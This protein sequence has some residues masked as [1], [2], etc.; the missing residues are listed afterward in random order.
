[1]MNNKKELS[2]EDLHE[3]IDGNDISNFDPV[4]EA[5]KLYDVENAGFIPKG[6]LADIF[7]AYGFDEMSNE[8]INTLVKAADIDGDGKVTLKDFRH[9]MGSIEEVLSMHTVQK[10]G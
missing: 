7:Q 3:M 6:R 5:F 9:M 2:L 8:D 10:N 1:M 4:E